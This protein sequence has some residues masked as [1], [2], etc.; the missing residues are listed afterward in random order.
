[1]TH[2]GDSQQLSVCTR[3]LK[4]YYKNANVPAW[5]AAHC[6]WSRILRWQNV[7]NMVNLAITLII[8]ALQLGRDGEGRFPMQL[9]CDIVYL[10][11]YRDTFRVPMDDTD[12][13][14]WIVLTG[15]RTNTTHT[16][17]WSGIIKRDKRV[18]FMRPSVGD[19][20]SLCLLT[21]S[22]CWLRKYDCCAYFRR[23]AVWWIQMPHAILRLIVRGFDLS[24]ERE[25]SRN[26]VAGILLDSVRSSNVWVKSLYLCVYWVQTASLSLTCVAL[27][28]GS[29]S[30]IRKGWKNDYS[31]SHKHS[32]HLIVNLII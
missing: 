1:M 18:Y 16:F 14:F 13:Y 3:I 10:C 31:P 12:G 8:F 4:R 7:H 20:R 5:G 22:V 25:M 29:N 9:S 17:N 28:R 27:S 21:D 24:G 23:S 2:D 15:A 11:A 6:H 26:D 19:W 30:I 32:T